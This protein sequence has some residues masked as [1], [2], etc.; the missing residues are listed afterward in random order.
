MNDEHYYDKVNAIR[1]NLLLEC[2]LI[3][4]KSKEKI[5]GLF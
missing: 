4:Y 2:S 1:N 5:L 3:L